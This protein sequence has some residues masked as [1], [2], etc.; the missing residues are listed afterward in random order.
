MTRH[1]WR[2]R[3]PAGEMLA[4][5]DNGDLNTASPD[6]A[7]ATEQVVVEAADSE[8]AEKVRTL[9]EERGVA[10]SVKQASGPKRKAEHSGR[11]AAD[12]EASRRILLMPPP[13]GEE[14][15]AVLRRGVW[16][17]VDPSERDFEAALA[18]AIEQVAAGKRPAIADIAGDPEAVAALMAAVSSG[19]ARRGATLPNPLSLNEIEILSRIASGQTSRQIAEDLGFHLQTVKN[20]VT[21]ILGKTNA[22]SRGHAAAIAQANGWIDTWPDRS[23]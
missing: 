4:R 16:A 9:V 12:F 10:L 14:L 23:S 7:E 13:A 21:I 15:V 18:Q 1:A 19:P 2:G 8:T 11:A 3:R 5:I 22:N 17:F 6:K 20:R